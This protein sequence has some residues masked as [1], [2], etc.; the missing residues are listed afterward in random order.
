MI[1]LPPPRADGALSLE[2]ALKARRSIRSYGE[3][4]LT[5]AEVAQLLWAAQGTTRRNGMRTVPSAGAL[6]PLELYL[7]VG[8]VEQLPVGIYHYDSAGHALEERGGAARRSE[9]LAAGYGQGCIERGAMNIVVAAVYA[10]TA[11]KYG[12]RAVRYAQLEAGHAA[13]NL[14]LQAVVLGLG[15]VVVGAFDDALVKQ[16][17]GMGGDE[18]PLCIMPVGRAK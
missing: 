9:L 16:A 17:L 15:T 4:A 14:A 7:E 1:P 8:R 2:A 3:Q 11:R 18:E 13:Q 12:E 5:L 10:R 6:Y